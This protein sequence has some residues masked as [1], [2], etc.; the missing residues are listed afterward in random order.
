MAGGKIAFSSGTAA[1]AERQKPSYRPFLNDVRSGNLSNLPDRLKD[2]VQRMQEA[3]GKAGAG[4][5]INDVLATFASTGN[6]F[7]MN[8]A[9]RLT[10]AAEAGVFNHRDAQKIMKELMRECPQA[11]DSVPKMLADLKRDLGD[12]F[13]GLSAGDITRIAGRS[14]RASGS[15]CPKEI[16]RKMTEL[17]I[18]GEFDHIPQ[19]HALR[20][21]R[22]AASEQAVAIS[23]FATSSVAVQAPFSYAEFRSVQAVPDY[24]VTSAAEK[25][26][27][28]KAVEFK[29]PQ[30]MQHAS[31]LRNVPLAE[32][33]MQK[34]AV[35][36]VP[37]ATNQPLAREPVL[38]GREEHRAPAKQ[39]TEPQAKTLKHAAAVAEA[40]QRMSEPARGEAQKARPVLINAQPHMENK[41]QKRLRFRR[42]I[43]SRL[44]A[45]KS[46]AVKRLREK[47]HTPI[48]RVRE[49]VRTAKKK[50]AERRAEA[51][52]RRELK[53]ATAK[54][55]PKKREK[56][57]I[58]A[59][60]GKKKA[61]IA[62]H[63]PFRM[64]KAKGEKG[65][66][67]CTGKRTAPR[68]P[69]MFR[70][71]SRLRR[72]RNR[73]GF[74]KFLIAPGFFSFRRQRKSSAIRL[75]NHF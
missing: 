46:A 30:Q 2:V 40:R 68:G 16:H 36:R 22:A 54:R 4:A 21:E 38:R 12:R 10:E 49:L 48:N 5:K 44:D 26:I 51:K 74:L 3:G 55:V 28:P 32:T 73:P 64:K 45:A 31:K 29:A 24:S 50:I 60:I 66:V 53:P 47:L 67:A 34:D 62:L 6:Q 70:R 7:V 13:Y 37:R 23:E 14:L 8:T 63:L 35:Q 65:R 1:T 18:H 58:V 57:A 27:S 19:M 43:R 17:T 25:Q 20:M 11:A 72:G 59:A 56:P 41:K 75:R 71:M 42:K 9:S 33:V 39:L 52:K 69:A 61:K 15:H